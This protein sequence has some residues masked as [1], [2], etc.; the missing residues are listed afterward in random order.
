MASKAL[1]ERL[2]KRWFPHTTTPFI[3]NAPMFGFADCRLA[4]AVTTAGGLGMY[5]SCESKNY[6]QNPNLSDHGPNW[7]ARSGTYTQA[8]KKHVAD[9]L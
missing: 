9:D 1:P 4:G 8:R 5:R 2:L 6:E 3:A 7:L